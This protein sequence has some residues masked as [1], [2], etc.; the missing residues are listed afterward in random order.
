[1]L[2]KAAPVPAREVARLGAPLAKNDEREDYL[3]ALL[4]R[5][6]AGNLIATPFDVQDSSMLATIARSDCLVVR[7][8]HAPAAAVGDRV[9]FVRL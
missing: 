9:T 7:A 3:R 2:G 6:D 8:P 4:S 1:M 5:D